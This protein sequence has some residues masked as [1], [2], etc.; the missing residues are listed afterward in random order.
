MPYNKSALE[1][2]CLV[3]MNKNGKKMRTLTNLIK[4][5]TVRCCGLN[6]EGR[7]KKVKID[8]VRANWVNINSENNNRYF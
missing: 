2:A 6:S 5:Y 7:R 8:E 3:K 4:I 1:Q